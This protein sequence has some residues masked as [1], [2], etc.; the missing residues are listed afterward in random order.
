MIELRFGHDCTQEKEE[1]DIA[2]RVISFSLIYVNK[3]SLT[4]WVQKKSGAT[5]PRDHAVKVTL[6]NWATWWTW[7]RTSRCR[8]WMTRVG[9]DNPSAFFIYP[10]FLRGVYIKRHSEGKGVKIGDQ[11][12]K[13]ESESCSV[14]SNSTWPHGLYSPWN[15]PGQNI[16][17][18]SCSLLQG[19]FLI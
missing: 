7:L 19:I 17:V 9:R 15:S 6:E 1:R 4:G 11:T 14:M 13:I 8:G 16:G 2:L 10:D 12:I 18:G 3:L 5:V